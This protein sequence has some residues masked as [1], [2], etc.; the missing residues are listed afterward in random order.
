MLDTICVQQLTV[1]PGL[2][3]CGRDGFNVAAFF[4]NLSSLAFT[5]LTLP[6]S[7][8]FCILS[9]AS[10]EDEDLLPAN[11][12]SNSA[13]PSILLPLALLIFFGR[14]GLSCFLLVIGDLLTG[15]IA[16]LLLG[17]SGGEGGGCVTRF[18]IESLSSTCTP[19][20]GALEVC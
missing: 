13:V 18:S 1:V 11:E 2:G 17:G 4:S 8:A 20:T 3:F 6:D 5:R 10:F 9:M 15:E 7:S 16:A 14:E 12:C 19:P